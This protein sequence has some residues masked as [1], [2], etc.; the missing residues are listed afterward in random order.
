M[1]SEI[2]SNGLLEKLSA[3]QIKQL[4]ELRAKEQK[5]SRIEHLFPDTG[6]LRRELYVKHMEFFS[7]GS[8]YNDR[9]FMAANRVGKTIEGGTETSY[10]LTGRYPEWW[11]GRRFSDP[12]DWWAAGDTAETTRDICQFELLGPISDLGTGLIPHRFIVGNPKQRR[13]IPEALDVVRV[14]HISGGISTLQFKSFDQGRRKFQGTAKDGIWLD[15][16]PPE[17]VFDECLIRTMTKNGLMIC[18]FTPLKG[19]SKVALKYLPHLAPADTLAEEPDEG[20]RRVDPGAGRRACVQATWDDAPHLTEAQK[21][22]LYAKMPVHQRDA[23]SKGVPQLGSGQIYPVAEEDLLC[24]PFELP[25]WYEYCFALDV[26]WNRTACLWGARDTTSDIL[27]LFAEHYRGQAEP[28][29]HAEAIKARGVW[30]PG[31]IDPASRGRQ[32]KDGEQLLRI[33]QALGLQLTIADN[34]VDSGIYE[35]WT[36]MST[37]RLK[38]FRTLQNLRSELRIYRRDEKGHVVKEN[39]HLT[40]CLRYMVMSGLKLGVSKPTLLFA[41][42]RSAGRHTVDYD[43]VSSFYRPQ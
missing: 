36:R 17:D 27:Y 35:V 42:E 25:A 43:P 29:I 9:C 38:I 2:Y 4:S 28:V 24:D 11:P 21:A 22:D 3:E 37:G 16:E 31:V 12:V 32:Q 5:R 8:E 18:T 34:S 1:S 14:Q 13:G 7:L 40:D 20:Q 19:L 6:P 30:M 33:Y 23:R 41:A 15:E 26:G 39:D 10:H